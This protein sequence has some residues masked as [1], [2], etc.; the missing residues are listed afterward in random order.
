MREG[1]GKGKDRAHPHGCSSELSLPHSTTRERGL[2]LQRT[3]KAMHLR[4]RS[5]H[6]EG[7][8]T[9]ARL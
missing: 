8:N 2:T 6:H 9:T 4:P 5:R 1:M 3:S 7:V